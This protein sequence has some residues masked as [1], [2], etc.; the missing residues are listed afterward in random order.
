MERSDLLKLKKYIGQVSR[1][2]SHRVIMFLYRQSSPAVSYSVTEIL[3]KLGMRQTD[4]S[5][6][7]GIARKMGLVNFNK[8]GKFKYYWAD[9]KAIDRQQ[10]QVSNVLSKYK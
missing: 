1:K 2:D 3:N 10:R 9:H 4:V 6:A 7:L 8:I 5:H